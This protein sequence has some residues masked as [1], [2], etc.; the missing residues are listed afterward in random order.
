MAGV[1]L[2]SLGLPGLWLD[3]AFDVFVLGFKEE[4]S[5]YYLMIAIS[6]AIQGHQA[7]FLTQIP[8]SF[9]FQEATEAPEP[10]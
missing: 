8:L 5:T 3:S 4:A 2:V 9:A 1:T 7:L 6:T 10:H